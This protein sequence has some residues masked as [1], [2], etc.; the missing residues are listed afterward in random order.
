[1]IR[2][3][4]RAVLLIGILV[5]VVLVF[6]FPTDEIARWIVARVTPPGTTSLTFRSARLR[7]NG[8]HLEDAALRRADGSAL[9][10]AP[11]VRLSPSWLSLLGERRGRPWALGAGLCTGT[12]DLALDADGTDQQ[13]DVTWDRLDL[14]TCLPDLAPQLELTGVGTGQASLRIPPSG[15][16]SGSGVFDL[17]RAVWEVEAPRLGPITVR[18][19]ET[20][21]RW[22]IDPTQLTVER[23]S[24]A[25]PDVEIEMDGVVHLSRTGSLGDATLDVEADVVLVP[26]GDASVQRLF[27]AFPADDDGTRRLHVTGSLDA[28]R[29]TSH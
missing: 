28:P 14:A 8:L 25:G 1:V 15:P 3:V 27:S 16:V 11:W 9:L 6:A 22:T 26:G 29:V 13:L 17:S 10:E 24:L 5:T 12:V 23:F 7:P 20:K 21:L 4:A 19:D 18:G 2:R